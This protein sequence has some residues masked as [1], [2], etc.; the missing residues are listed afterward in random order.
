MKQGLYGQYP[1]PK[2]E[3]GTVRR[4][5]FAFHRFGQGANGS[6]WQV[7]SNPMQPAAGGGYQIIIRQT[8][9]LFARIA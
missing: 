1:R 3:S 4:Y 2:P 9:I 6:C 5:G 8:L 7:W